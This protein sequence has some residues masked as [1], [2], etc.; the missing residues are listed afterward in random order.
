M[1]LTVNT[2]GGI[3]SNISVKSDIPETLTVAQGSSLSNWGQDISQ[4]SRSTFSVLTMLR[5]AVI[6][7]STEGDWYGSHEMEGLGSLMEENVR[8][9]I[10]RYVLSRSGSGVESVAP[11]SK[12]FCVILAT[13]PAVKTREECR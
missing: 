6:A 13:L 5:K 10:F 8:R 4:R 9:R 2:Y 7:R 3:G 11:K 1:L 12:A